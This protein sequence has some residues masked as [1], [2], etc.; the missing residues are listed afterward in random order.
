MAT[1]E[2][3]HN[4]EIVDLHTRW[5][6][7]NYEQCKEAVVSIA[8]KLNYVVVNINDT[9]GELLVESSEFSHVFDISSVTPL[10]T[11]IDICV[12]SKKLFKKPIP[13]ICFLYEELNK[14]LKFRSKGSGL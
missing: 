5:Y 10:N 14:A 8:K 6:Q 7:N 13:Q 3:K 9:F 1:I 11:S 2:T 4:H 12:T